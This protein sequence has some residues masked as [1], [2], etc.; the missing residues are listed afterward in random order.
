MEGKMSEPPTVS[1][2][3]T[4]LASDALLG[5]VF[6]RIGKWPRLGTLM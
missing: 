1:T 6:T 2:T 4:A 5:I 3:G